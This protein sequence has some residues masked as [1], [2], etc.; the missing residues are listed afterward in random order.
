[1]SYEPYSVW[2]KFLY[3]RD[4]W[5]GVLLV[6]GTII[7]LTI[8]I[9]AVFC[10]SGP[11]GTATYTKSNGETVVVKGRIYRNGYNVEKDGTTHVLF[12]PCVIKYDE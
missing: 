6:G 4:H 12:D 10:L 8:I 7:V 1:M 11:T 5:F 2:D 3:W 9:S